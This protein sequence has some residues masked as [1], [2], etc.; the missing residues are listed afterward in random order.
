MLV[1]RCF[2]FWRVWEPAGGADR[3]DICWLVPFFRLMDI[4]ARRPG[5]TGYAGGKWPAMFA[6]LE[7]T[8]KFLYLPSVDRVFADRITCQIFPRPVKADQGLNAFLS[9]LMHSAA[10]LYSAIDYR[11][12]DSVRTNWKPYIILASSRLC[13]HISIVA[14]ASHMLSDLMKTAGMRMIS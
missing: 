13:V 3:S 4:E 14:R 10:A 12:D 1:R 6:F 2:R 7:S 11:A 9:S 5:T 8:V